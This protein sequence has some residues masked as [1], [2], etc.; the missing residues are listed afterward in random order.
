M[1]ANDSST[2]AD[3][4]DDAPNLWQIQ[5]HDLIL[6]NM[7]PLVTDSNDS[8]DGEF[9]F[10]SASQDLSENEMSNNPQIE[11]CNYQT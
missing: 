5:H 1:D 4:D 8:S 10:A 2:L 6:Q 11:T 3:E 7:S 9:S